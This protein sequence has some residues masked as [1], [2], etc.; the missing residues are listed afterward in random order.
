MFIEFGFPLINSSIIRPLAA[1]AEGAGLFSVVGQ[2]HFLRSP[3]IQFRQTSTTP[4]RSCLGLLYF[5]R[6][7]PALLDLVIRDGCGD[8]AGGALGVVG[9]ASSCR[10]ERGGS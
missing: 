3:T 10:E 9:D 1:A 5:V 2:A 7:E 6:R 4:W 8:H